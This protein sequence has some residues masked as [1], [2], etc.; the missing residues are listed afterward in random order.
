MGIMGEMK[1]MA[2]KSG[3]E[4]GERYT[5]LL[6]AKLMGIITLSELTRV[7]LMDAARNKRKYD[8]RDNRPLPT[9]DKQKE[10]IALK[11]YSDGVFLE[12]IKS[13]LNDD[14][15]LNEKETEWFNFIQDGT[16]AGS[17]SEYFRLIDPKRELQPAAV[18]AD[19]VPF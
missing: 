6:G 19:D 17:V 1:E 14:P 3:S 18:G 9:E 15:A 10:H 16:V 2:D 4:L 12:Q 7:T 8:Y 13:F 11:N 5:A